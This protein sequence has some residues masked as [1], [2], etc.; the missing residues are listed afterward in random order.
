MIPSPVQKL[1]GLLSKSEIQHGRRFSEPEID[2]LSKYF[3]LVLKWNPRL[4]LTTLTRPESFLERHILESALSTSLILPT[5]TQVWDL[6]SGLGVPGII[7]A[8]LRPELSVRLVEASRNKALFLEE[9]VSDLG[10]QNVRVVQSRF[11]TLGEIGSSSC[12]TVRAIEEMERLI[13]QI[14]KLGAEAL[15]ILIF[16]SARIE[17]K[18]RE[19]LKP[20]QKI[21]SLLIPGS[22]A[23]YLITISR[24]T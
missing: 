9:A 8:A 20:N 4:H 24:S 18:A 22:T 5:I 19:T 16:G 21:E 12:L 10:L 13:P 17:E 15:Q 2:L 3:E 1:K 11:E 7:I 6:G 14:L 23:R